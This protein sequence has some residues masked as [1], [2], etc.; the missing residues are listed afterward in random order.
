MELELGYLLKPI[1][2]RERPILLAMVFVTG[3]I[4]KTQVCMF[5]DI[6]IVV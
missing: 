4:K 1:T 3:Q 2:K 6:L 5:N